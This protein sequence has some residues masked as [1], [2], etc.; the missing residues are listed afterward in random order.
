[1]H[2]RSL[3]DLVLLRARGFGACCGMPRD[4]A[5]SVPAETYHRKFASQFSHQRD[6]PP[7]L[8]S[9]RQRVMRE[10]DCADGM[11]SGLAWGGSGWA[12]V[13]TPRKDAAGRKAQLRKSEWFIGGRRAIGLEPSPTEG[14]KAEAAK[15]KASYKSDIEVARR[16]AAYYESVLDLPNAAFF[17]AEMLRLDP[18]NMAAKSD[19]AQIQ[20]YEQSKK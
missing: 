7:P 12:W 2:S 17:L 10:I 19:L 4:S 20:A 9:P 6:T 11:C 5:V 13:A 8:P 3:V 14:A 1:M 15:G 18:G 16:A